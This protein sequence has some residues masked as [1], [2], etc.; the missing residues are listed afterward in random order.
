VLINGASGG[1]GIFAVQIAK[2]F[3]AEVTGVCSA[4]NVELVRSLGADHVIDYRAAD[5][6]RSG[7]KYDVILDNVGN[8]SPWAN[9]RALAPGGRLVMVGGPSGNWVGPLKNPLQALFLSPFVDQQFILFL[10]RLDQQDLTQLGELMQSGALNPVI[11]RRYTLAEVP[12]AIGY[13]EAGRARGK[14]V[15]TVN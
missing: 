11:D 7:Q 8:H 9:R 10:A 4:R 15:I 12:A 6:T 13:S 3:G 1:V 5:Y 14:I 2:L